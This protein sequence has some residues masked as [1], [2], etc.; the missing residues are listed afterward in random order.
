MLV[1]RDASLRP[2]PTLDSDTSVKVGQTPGW[3]PPWICLLEGLRGSLGKNGGRQTDGGF[4]RNN[5]PVSKGNWGYECSSMPVIWM[6]SPWKGILWLVNQNQTE[7]AVYTK[8][9]FGKPLT[10]CEAQ[11]RGAFLPQREHRWA[12]EGG[13]QGPDI[14]VQDYVLI[15][16][17]VKSGGVAACVLWGQGSIMDLLTWV[18]SKF[19]MVPTRSRVMLYLSLTRYCIW[20]VI[21]KKKENFSQGYE[22]WRQKLM[23]M[24]KNIFNEP[25][26]IFITT[27]GR[28][29]VYFR[30]N[31]KKIAKWDLPTYKI[32]HSSVLMFFK[33]HESEFD[34]S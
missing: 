29:K 12:W 18:F 3:G 34:Y 9:C 8:N 30:S 32:K 33:M 1:G 20:L 6:L 15:W 24:T 25:L 27:R 28:K 5:A 26:G 7:R 10:N 11:G 13:A 2:W 23:K 22:I 16:R 21:E 31:H 19:L 17:L 4:P 14:R